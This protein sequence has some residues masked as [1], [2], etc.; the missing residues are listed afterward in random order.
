MVS[1]GTFQVKPYA[2]THAT[3]IAVTLGFPT[4]PCKDF[5]FFFSYFLY[6][7][8]LRSLVV[9]LAQDFPKCELVLCC[10]GNE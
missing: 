7:V 1:F 8:L 6:F 9:L 4:S 2:S 3:M 10:L 5:S